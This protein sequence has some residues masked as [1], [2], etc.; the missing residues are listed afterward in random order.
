MDKLNIVIAED[1]PVQAEVTAAMVKLLRP[2]WRVVA[3]AAS[4]DET[5]DVVVR[6]QP[7]LVLL[8]I[9]LQ[10]PL[11]GLDIAQEVAK[12]CALVFI[13]GQPSHALAAFDVGAIDYLVKPM[14][15]S[16][17]EQALVRT[18]KLLSDSAIRATSEATEDMPMSGQARYMQLSN[19]RRLIWTSVGEVRYLQAEIGYTQVFLQDTWGLIRQS[20]QSVFQRLNHRDFWQI[21]RGTVINARYVQDIERDDLGRMSVRLQD[22]TNRLLVAKN[23]EKLFK[24][25]FTN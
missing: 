14:S 24:D 3:T 13:T 15:T 22:Y 6:Y 20:L 25:D 19:G 17:L 2:N 12:H 9:G 8:D 7:D 23:L 21:H 1:S 10:G 16:R 4:A 11:S 18:E 5:L